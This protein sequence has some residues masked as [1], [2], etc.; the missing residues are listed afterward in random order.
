MSIILGISAYYHDSAAALLQDGSIIAA[1]QEERFTRIKHD[2]SFPKH[3]IQYCLQAAQLSLNDVTHIVFYDK[4][5]LKF[6][7]LL[8]SYLSSVP[9]GLRS[10]SSAM[11]VWIKEKLFLKSTLRKALA[12]LGQCPQKSLPLL[13]FTEHHQSHAASAFYPSPY[14]EAAVLCLDGVGEWA[15]T[16]LW[17]GKGNQLTPKWQINF[18]HSLGLFYSAITYFAGFKVNSGEYKLMGLAPYGLPKYVDVLRKNVI[19]IKPDGTFRLNARYFNYISGLT[20]THPRLNALLDGPPRMPESP[21]TQREMDIARSVQAITEEIVLRLAQTAQQE[22]KI[23]ALCLAGGVALNCVANGQLRA[24]GPFE[25]LWI[26]PA[27]GDAGGALGAALSVYHDYLAQPRQ[28]QHGD[29]MAGSYLGPDITEAHI[30]GALAQH[31]APHT[32]LSDTALYREVA[33]LLDEGMVIG[34]VQGRME[35]GPRALGNRSIIGDPRS[36]R[37]QSTMNLKIKFRESFR[38]FAPAIKYDKVS[39]WFSIVG[40]SPYMLL[41][42]PVHPEKCYAMPETSDT[43]LQL[44]QAIRSQIPAVTHV[45]NSARIQTVHPETNPRFYALLDAFE[46]RTGCPA[47]INTSFNVRGEP[48]VCTAADAYRCFMRTGIDVLVI[49]NAILYKTQQPVW[50]ENNMEWKKEF[51]LD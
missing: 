49:N 27:A 21:L 35:F 39:E 11:P 18:P 25:H 44:L 51:V 40:A 20:M 24:K 7:R 14:D 2:A 1:A 46:Q 26:Q 19:D 45:D 32:W 41:V 28:P 33:R 37:M 8:E 34:W 12:E 29:S 30:L 22:L 15:T 31:H 42:A 50:A 23:N 48:I 47:V 6:E 9:R 16:S 17:H 3:A 36:P 43:G 38:P 10:F 5:L 4:P 13:L